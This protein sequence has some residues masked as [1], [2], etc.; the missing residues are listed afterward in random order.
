[1]T[2]DEAQWQK[3]LRKLAPKRVCRKCNK[4]VHSLAVHQK[5]EHP[6]AS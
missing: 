4:K 3:T 5:I 6:R 2:S 1:M